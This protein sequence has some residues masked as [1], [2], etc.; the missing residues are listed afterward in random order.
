MTLSP[1]SHV[2]LLTHRTEPDVVES[3][4]A[5][6]EARYQERLEVREECGS[7]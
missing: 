5:A 2:D 6:S 1:D 7:A 4:R 3:E